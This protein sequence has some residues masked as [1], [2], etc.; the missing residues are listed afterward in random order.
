MLLVGIALLIKGAL[1]I[2]TF[3]IKLPGALQ[4]RHYCPKI[5]LLIIVTAGIFIPSLVVGACFGRILGLGMEWI[6]FH[7]SNL[8]IFDVCR[9]TD[10][11][12]PGLYAMVSRFVA[13]IDAL[14]SGP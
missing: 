1:T 9:E 2:I 14:S 11:I 6:E 5:G 13:P 10:C 12:V 8:T 4:K 7:H 3:G